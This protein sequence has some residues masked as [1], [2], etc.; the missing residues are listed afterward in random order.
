MKNIYLYAHGGSGNHGCEAI[1]RSTVKILKEMGYNAPILISAN[2]EEDSIYGVNQICKIIKD[3]QP[4][5]KFSLDFLHAYYDL[6]IKKD[7]TSMDELAYK[8]VIGQI[9]PGDIVL[10]I[11]GDNYCYADVK[12]YVMLH[13]MVLKRGA[14][15]V[16][17]GCSVEPD[18]VKNPEIAEDLSHYSLIVARE[19]ISYEA[20]KKVNANTILVSD[21]AF[22]L[23]SIKKTEE[24]NIVGINISPMVIS[25]ERCQGSAMN[26]YRKLI[27]YILGHT[28]MDIM[29]IPHVVW[30]DNDDRIPIE[31]LYSEFKDSNRIEILLDCPCEEIK[32]VIE[33][34]KYF[35]G[36]RTHSTIA[37]YSTGV[38]TLVLG[39]SVKARGI[40][41]D[42]FGQEN[43]YIIPVQKLDSDEDLVNEFK[44]I[45]EEREYIINKLK[46]YKKF[47]EDSLTEIKK[48]FE[49]LKD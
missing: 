34:C 16:L 24:R 47:S 19:S 49:N 25:N 14:K 31:E 44:K 42:I 17:W 4:Y 21:P 9:K 10:S 37:A 3:K 1:V 38:P 29:L 43:R 8:R 23:D 13:N 18:I 41:K 22:L 33:N 6:K 5:S 2:P 35:V 15:T 20:L 27:R 7:F 46:E 45:M 26:C 48:A 11:G 32:G 28:D 30:D 40:A 39:Y 12:K 36:A